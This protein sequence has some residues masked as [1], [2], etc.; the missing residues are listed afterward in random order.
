LGAEHRELVTV[1]G[2][3]QPDKPMATLLGSPSRREELRQ[4]LG[5]L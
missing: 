2:E 4:A 1:L 3:A 5:L